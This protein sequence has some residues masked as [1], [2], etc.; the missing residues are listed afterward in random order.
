M[1][2]D[3]LSAEK[4][5]NSDLSGECPEPESILALFSGELNEKQANSTQRHIKSCSS[6]QIVMDE[7]SRDLSS[8]PTMLSQLPSKPA[9]KSASGVASEPP[10]EESKPLGGALAT[11]TM[12]AERYRVEHFV[13]RGG[14][15]EIYEVH[16]V[17]LGENVAL[18]TLPFT[19][20]ANP[21]AIARLKI[22]VKLS[23]RVG[24]AHTCR[25]FDFGKH[26]GDTPGS[27]LHF[28]TMEFVQ[29]NALGKLL[30]DEGALEPSIVAPLALQMLDGLCAAHKAGV[31]HRDFKSDNVMLRPKSKRHRD[32]QVVILDFGLAK[33][34]HQDGERLTSNSQTL[35]GSAAYM[36]PE[37]A[38]GQPLTESADLYALGIVLFE[39]LT[40]Q[41]PFQSN[42]PMSTVLLRLRQAAPK[43]SRRNPELLPA[44]DDLVAG[45]LR[46]DISKRFDAAQI[47]QA[48]LDLRPG[49]RPACLSF[50]NR[51]RAVS[52]VGGF[53]AGCAGT[54]LLAW[55]ILWSPPA[56]VPANTQPL[57]VIQ[58]S[59]KVAK[60]TGTSA[61]A[62]RGL[63]KK[64]DTLAARWRERK[65]TSDCQI[66][67]TLYTQYL[68]L[69]SPNAPTRVGV[70]TSLA[71][72]GSCI[73]LAATPVAAS[74]NVT[75][76][77][78]AVRKASVRTRTYV[79]QKNAPRNAS[80]QPSATIS[81]KPAAA[82]KPITTT[83]PSDH[84]FDGFL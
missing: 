48:L 23:R 65:K 80:S 4:P 83:R 41:L 18:K 79:A 70:E 5:A 67:Q 34:L 73:G 22:E 17:V 54:A 28:L 42:S 31:L 81:P 59:L 66:A 74:P 6:C 20:L 55:G 15:G 77:A 75:L 16:D 64:A 57:G 72:L 9:T 78:P 21:E 29:G 44:W 36:A 30:R 43:P 26:V 13:A 45:C 60:A 46:R 38:V 7:A 32:F 3:A 84:P 52:V 47:R 1:R 10:S 14:M 40:G 51:H 33:A 68:E 11:G 27:A 24:N 25:I 63:L 58:Q 2:P 12:I 50:P 69:V 82:S 37:Q 8:H 71:L 49:K 76:A 62:L 35:L 39:M 53:L 56:I 19:A 61:R